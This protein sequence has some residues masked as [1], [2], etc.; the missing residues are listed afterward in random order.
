MIFKNS[1]PQKKETSLQKDANQSQS[2]VLG[3]SRKQEKKVLTLQ[4]SSRFPRDVKRGSK[5]LEQL[6]FAKTALGFIS[7]LL[8]LMHAKNLNI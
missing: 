8:A 4:N 2:K 6:F 1:E 3:V 5:A 7:I